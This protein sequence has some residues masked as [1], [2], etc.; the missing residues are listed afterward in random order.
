MTTG[1]PRWRPLVA[2]V[3]SGALFALAF[4]PFELPLLAPVALIPW[5][6]ALGTEEKRGRG[7]V[8]GLVFG[9]TYWC[10][11]IPWIF[12]VVT[13]F[14][15]QSKATGVLSLAILALILA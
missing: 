15:S 1:G 5:I 12:Y 4:P 2:G 9:L 7:L 13:R 10:L 14:G 6:A 8:S 11:S 3:F